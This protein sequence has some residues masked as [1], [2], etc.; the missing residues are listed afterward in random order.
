[1][2]MSRLHAIFIPTLCTHWRCN[3]MLLYELSDPFA[4]F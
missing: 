1:M 4:T 3:S 2:A